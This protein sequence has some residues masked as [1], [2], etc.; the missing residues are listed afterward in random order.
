MVAHNSSL[1]FRLAGILFFVLL[2]AGELPCAV[3]ADP[4][5][6]E[7]DYYRMITLPLPQ[8][9]VL[10]VGGLEWLD[11]ERKR[12]LVCTRRGEIWVVDNPYASNPVLPPTDVDAEVDEKNIV[13][14]KRMLFGL[15][16][17]LGLLR[18]DDGVYLAQ[19]GELTRIND[20]NGDDRIDRVETVC[21]DWQIS[22]S[23]HEYAFGP[24]LDKNGNFVVTLNRPFGG[25]PEGKA[26][27]RGWAVTID[28][29]G[30]MTPLCAGL[31]SPAG[32]GANAAG[33]LFYTDN[34]G[35]WVAACKLSHLKP[36][37]FQGN[38]L[39]FFSCDDPRSPIKD[40]QNPTSGLPLAEAAE[41]MPW[42]T[43]PAVWFPYPRMGKSH[44]DVLCDQT[45]GKFGPFD[46]QLFVGD[47]STS[48][49]TRVFLEKVAGEYQGACF[50]FRKGFQCGV[51]R[52]CWGHDGSMF[53]GQTNRGWGSTGG[54]PY[55]LER[56]AWTG[57][58]PF[59]IHEMRARPD[60]FELTFTQPVD[61]RTA[62]DVASYSMQSW[63][64]HYH[65]AYGCKP[66]DPHPLKVT[67][68][69]VTDDR[70][71]VRLMV[72][73]IQ[74]GYIHELRA[75]GIRNGDDLPLLHDEAYYTLNQI[76]K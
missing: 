3:A 35:D 51:M 50:P 10:E 61:P 26:L 30:K 68:A 70:R 67:Q 24:K 57:K 47:Q 49:I 73:G 7:D 15:H 58:T 14:F 11:K 66:I 38:P 76:P 69:T 75:P 36:G 5:P 17:P 37:S 41:K 32:I 19:R 22:G 27:W 71:S 23:Y 43:M 44:S 62:G 1:S 46:K 28:H 4:P 25:E 40:P 31:R 53:V 60:G 56:L 6:T 9:T 39:A 59:E 33:D 48:I 18:Q 34:Q 29:Q 20:D 55:G 52:M 65:S 2:T 21:N 45:G 16:E 8:E 74:P 13:L 64:Y 54:K 72:N 12:L 63:T 42:V